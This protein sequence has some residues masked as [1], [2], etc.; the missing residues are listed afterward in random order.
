VL[1]AHPACLHHGITLT[2]ATTIVWY[3]PVTSL[4]IYEQANARIRRVGQ[5]HKQLFLHIQSTAVE[6]KVYAMLRSKQRMQDRFLDLIKTSVGS[7]HD[8]TQRE[9]GEQSENG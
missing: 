3:S 7:D 2:A 6:R 4:E 8:K 9:A 5:Q 1:L